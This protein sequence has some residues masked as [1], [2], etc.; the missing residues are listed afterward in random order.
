[1]S[2]T[3]AIQFNT[4]DSKQL[5]ND[6][7]WFIKACLLTFDQMEDNNTIKLLRIKRVSG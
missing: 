3:L 7:V 6:I 5:Q 4:A 2:L 1:M